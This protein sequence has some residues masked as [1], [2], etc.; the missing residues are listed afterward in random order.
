MNIFDKNGHTPIHYA[1]YKNIDKVCEI[2]INFV[3][4]SEDEEETNAALPS[5]VQYSD[6]MRHANE[7]IRKQKKH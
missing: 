6:D 4:S 2:L 3:L 1:A 5:N 7:K